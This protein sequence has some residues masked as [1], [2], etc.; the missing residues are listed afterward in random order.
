MAPTSCFTEQF[1]RLPDAPEAYGAMITRT[2]PAPAQNRSADLLL[3]LT[4][5]TRYAA[6]AVSR[7]TSL[8]STG[9]P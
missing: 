7:R 5:A 2:K 8:S 3:T 9:I 6:G 4:A 1:H